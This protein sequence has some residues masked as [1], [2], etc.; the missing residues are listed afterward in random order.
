MMSGPGMRFLV[1][2]CDRCGRDKGVGFDAFGGD[3][4]ASSVGLGPY[5]LE[6]AR[7]MEWPPAIRTQR[8]EL[9]Q[10][11][12][13]I[14]GAC[15]CGGAFSLDAPA[16]CPECGSDQFVLEPDDAPILFD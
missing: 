11:V 2:H 7:D 14:A 1:F 12:E 8:A 6:R 15:P 13:A 3:I 10:R 9:R 5:T 4:E 16:R